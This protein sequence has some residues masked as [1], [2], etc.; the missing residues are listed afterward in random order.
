MTPVRK[1]FSGM[2]LKAFAD[3]GRGGSLFMYSLNYSEKS[4]TISTEGNKKDL[5]SQIFKSC[6]MQTI[7]EFGI[8]LICTHLV[9]L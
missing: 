7:G 9:N 4:V 3:G 2:T 5:F 8:I 1:G 6:T